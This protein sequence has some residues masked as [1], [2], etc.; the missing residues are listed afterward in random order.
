LERR[1]VVLV[2]HHEGRGWTSRNCRDCGSGGKAVDPVQ[3]R[4]PVRRVENG[5]LGAGIRS[6]FGTLGIA[7]IFGMK[8]DERVGRTTQSF[9]QRMR[10]AERPLCGVRI[11][12]RSFCRAIDR[13]ALGALRLPIEG[14]H[15][16]HQ[17]IAVACQIVGSHRAPVGPRVVGPV[18]AGRRRNGADPVP[19][20]DDREDR[21]AGLRPGLR[22]GGLDARR[23][24]DRQ[25][26]EKCQGGRNRSVCASPPLSPDRNDRTHDR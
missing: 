8:D 16:R 5:I 26:R 14:A 25:D 9:D 10:R 24:G 13:Q 22:R 7:G 2:S 21:A 20:D 1:E 6:D 23:E 15:Q 12:E 18:V 3:S 17:A 11:D 19:G 4:K